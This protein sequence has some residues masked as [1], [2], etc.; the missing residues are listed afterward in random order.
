MLVA[1]M[2]KHVPYLDNMDYIG[3]DRGALVCMNQNIPLCCAVGDFDS[4]SAQELALL[5]VYTKIKKLPAHKN[6]TDSEEGI[7]IALEEGYDEI[8]LYGGLGGRMDH[9]LA[10]IHMMIYRDVPITLMDEHNIICVLKP[11]VYSAEKK[12]KYLSFLALEPSCI[13]ET[14][15]E[16]PLHK[17]ELQPSD[18]YA[19]SNEI[20][21]THGNI[22]LHYG[23][24][25]M[26]QSDDAKRIEN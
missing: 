1:G 13:S 11:G 10:N 6:E 23:K 12:H 5:Y 17:Q 18:I 19:I 2:A 7:A 9:E 22:E 15:V 24:V 8:I 16:Y 14:G 26:I 25:L 21:H 20:I 3:I 4:V